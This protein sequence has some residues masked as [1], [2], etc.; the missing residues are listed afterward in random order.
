MYNTSQKVFR[1]FLFLSHSQCRD[2]LLSFCFSMRLSRG[3]VSDMHACMRC[4][5]CMRWFPRHPRY[6]R[7]VKSRRRISLHITRSQTRLSRTQYTS[8]VGRSCCSRQPILEI[9][10]HRRRH[11]FLCPELLTHRSSLSSQRHHLA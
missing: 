7:V 11:F 1:S 8:A 10:K 2:L 3:I 4:M 9:H 6:I 5:R